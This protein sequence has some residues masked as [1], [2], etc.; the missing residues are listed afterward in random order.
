MV[1]SL[2]SSPPLSDPS[3]ILHQDL[4]VEQS[5]NGVGWG[6]VGNRNLAHSDISRMLWA[7]LCADLGFAVVVGWSCPR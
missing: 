5:E 2:C 6:G 3:G 1:V 4:S 7:W